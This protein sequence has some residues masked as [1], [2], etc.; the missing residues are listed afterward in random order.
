VD[1][2][3]GLKGVVEQLKFALQFEKASNI[4]WIQFVLGLQPKPAK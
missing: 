3:D 1:V 2:D 4:H